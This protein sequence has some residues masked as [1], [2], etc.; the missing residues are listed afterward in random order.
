MT[1]LKSFGVAK[2]RS[3][4]WAGFLGMLIEYLVHVVDSVLLGRLV[5]IDALSAMNIGEPV[6][7]VICF[8]M[9]LLG[10][11]TATRY[12]TALGRCDLDGARRVFSESV[13]AAFGLGGL[14][15]AAVYLARDPLIGFL[16][17]EGAV[18]EHARAYFGAVTLYA[19]TG[20][21]MMLFNA[22]CYADGDTRLVVA[23]VAVS[24][25]LHVAFSAAACV[26]GFGAGGVGLA[27]GVSALVGI[28]VMTVHFRSP[29]C[30]YRPCL[31]FSPRGFLLSCRASFGDASAFLFSGLLIF[32]VTKLAVLS[33]GTEVLPVLVAVIAVWRLSDVYNGIAIALQPVITV[34]C[35]ENNTVSIRETMRDACRVS[36][37]VG[38]VIWAA[39]TVFAEP[40]VRGFGLVEPSAVATS[41]TAVRILAFGNIAYAFIGL[42]NSY[43]MFVD[44]MALAFALTFL[45]YFAAPAVGALVGSRFS[46]AGIWAGI[47][48]GAFTALAAVG[49]YVFCRYRAAR[50]PLMLDPGRDA[51]LTVFDLALTEREIADVAAKVR[52]IPGVPMRAGLITEEALM[53]VKDRNAGRRLR[54]EVTVER[55]NGEV[56]LILRDDGEI[57]DITDADASVSSLRTYLVAS[58]MERERSRVNL[59]TNGF[60]HNVF[61]FR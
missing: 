44:R 61:R 28:V 50:F 56:G 30:T 38:L 43:Y 16:S 57:F 26:F 11:G 39:L 41:V 53:V 45:G 40:F 51:E 48:A 55:R 25:V 29:A 33:A 20:P 58:L 27:S 59:I 9:T 34:Y 19:V 22:L 5:G 31:A 54:A 7:T 42:F 2:F 46:T 23:A 36:L 15:A 8:L 24:S 60:N 1:V 13:I 49:G 4:L 52:A 10:T 47:S 12:S 35:G 17:A 14:L 21:L 37:L 32:L 6:F 18:A 3:M